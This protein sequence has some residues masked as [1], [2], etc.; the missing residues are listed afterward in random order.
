MKKHFFGKIRLVNLSTFLFILLII[1]TGPGISTADE[2]AEKPLLIDGH[3][4]D[5]LKK[6]RT[7]F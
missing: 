4:H 1:L 5:D 3:S 7:L 2:N 6:G